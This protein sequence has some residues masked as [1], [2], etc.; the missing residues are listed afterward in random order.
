MALDPLDVARLFLGVAV[1]SFASYTD[2]RWRR[3]PN[4]LWWLLGGA[5]LALLALQ[6][7]VQP[8]LLAA[9]WPMLLVA[10]LF[11]GMA[12]AFHWLGLL[13]GGADAKALMALAVLLPFPLELGPFPL[14]QSLLPPAFGALGNALL[15][16]LAVPLGMLLVNAARRQAALPQA[17][18]GVRMRVARARKAHVW[19]MEFVDDDGAVRMTW[20]PS[21]FE[22]EDEDWDR[23]AK[24][25]RDEVWVTPKVPFMVPLLAG[26][27]ALC[28]VGDVLSGWVF[29][30]KP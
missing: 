7:A 11:A 17:L 25:G 12:F 24:A 10:G 16:F 2:W 4:A 20:M 22:W 30:L 8:G 27:V 28:F 26:F 14:R 5:G 29:A 23:L 21:R 13:P 19:P 18:L 6:L 3:A 1:L 9:R 15:A